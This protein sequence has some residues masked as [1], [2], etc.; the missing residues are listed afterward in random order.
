MTRDDMTRD[1]MTLDNRVRSAAPLILWGM[2]SPNVRK[3]ALM[4]EEIGLPYDL[5]HVSVFRGEQFTPGFLALNPLGKVPVLT[6]PALGA[7]LAESAAILFYLAEKHELFLPAHTPA[8]YEVMQWV[9][10]QMASI[11][12][13]LGQ[14]N[15]FQMPGQR[16]GQPYALGRYTEAARRL[17]R[18]LDDRLAD[19]QWI[20]GD[21]YSI[22]DIA[23]WPWATYLEQ[24]GFDPAGHP[25]LIRWRDAI[26]ARP[27]AARMVERTQAAFTAPSTA[28]RKSATAAELD[29]FFGRTSAMPA[30]DYTALTR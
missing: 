12:P 14:L 22:A 3:V 1:A 26:A 7:P 28:A 23:S 4:L 10:V 8:R 25:A 5:R 13:M 19:R 11:G 30:A 6:D 17:Y 20:A 2:N 9:M 18:L 24:H 21:A 27:A 29:Q 16:E 15:H